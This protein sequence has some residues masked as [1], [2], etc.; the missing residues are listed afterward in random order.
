[1]TCK[2]EKYEHLAERTR[3]TAGFIYWCQTCGAISITTMR[4]DRRWQL[5]ERVRNA[6]QVEGTEAEEV[7]LHL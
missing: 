6:A 5:P 2:H 1:M 7:A 3:G 4:E